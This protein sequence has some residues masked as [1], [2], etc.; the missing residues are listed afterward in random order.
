VAKLLDR[1]IIAAY[2]LT[3]NNYIAHD[4]LY[5][6]SRYKHRYTAQ[7]ATD[8]IAHLQQLHRYD[9]VDEPE[10]LRNILLGIYA[11]PVTSHERL[12]ASGK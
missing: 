11:N 3:P 5:A 12:A 6:Q 4:L 1:R 2:R 8:F 7:Q 10:V 9:Y